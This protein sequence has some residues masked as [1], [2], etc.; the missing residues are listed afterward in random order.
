MCAVVLDPSPLARPSCRMRETRRTT[1]NKRVRWESPHRPNSLG[2]PSGSR[3]Q[4]VAEIV[5]S[6][7]TQ[8]TSAECFC[9]LSSPFALIVSNVWK[10][11][12]GGGGAKVFY[13]LI[14]A[15]ARRINRMYRRACESAP[16][17]GR[18]PPNEP[19]SKE[20]PIELCELGFSSSSSP[21]E[22]RTLTWD[23]PVLGRSD[24][25]LFAEWIGQL[26]RGLPASEPA[27]RGL[28]FVRLLQARQ[29]QRA[30]GT[31]EM[32]PHETK[33]FRE[34]SSASE[35]GK[36]RVCKTLAKRPIC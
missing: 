15:N 5:Q 19:N 26:S 23:A 25:L 34:C 12:R 6:G 20:L 3:S 33:Q 7:R 36:C 14:K 24:E 4:L 17:D 30:R 35:N 18:Q 29:Q 27:G 22:S 8:V 13:I 16:F 1:H 11:S 28:F 21:C 31:N 2:L 32:I 10:F 9:C